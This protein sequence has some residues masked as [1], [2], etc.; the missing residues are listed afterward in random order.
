MPND[1]PIMELRNLKTFDV[2]ASLMSFNRA[3]AVLHCSQSTVSAQIRALEDDLGAPLFV[4]L[5]RR[6]SLT[7]AG[8][9]L[10]SRTRRILELEKET[11]AAVAGTAGPAGMLSL[12]V[13]Q[14][15]CAAYLPEILREFSTRYP[16]VGFDISNC[17]WFHLAEEMRSGAVD[18]AFLL[19]EDVV[20]PDLRAILVRVEELV[21]IASP[22][23]PLADRERLTIQDLS[24]QALLIPKHD[25]GYRMEFERSLKVADVRPAAIHEINSLTALL[26]CVGGGLGVAIVPRVAAAAAVSTGDLV[27]LDWKHRIETGLYFITHRDAP[28]TGT[29]GSFAALIKSWFA[30]LPGTKEFSSPR[31]QGF[32]GSCHTDS[33]YVRS[34][35]G[36]FSG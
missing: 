26:N 28:M 22:S 29:F 5:G 1:I 6:I 35:R 4:R 11:Y 14:S 2:V 3:S 17:G 23:S 16:R 25:C 33:E 15:V 31:T 13:P 20:S 12:R 21:F 24:G 19:A 36:G 30:A 34:L 18:G 7:A 27:T 10:L 8:Q 32:S 9:E